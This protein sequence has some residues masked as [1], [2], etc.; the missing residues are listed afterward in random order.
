MPDFFLSTI[1]ANIEEN[2]NVAPPLVTVTASDADSIAT[3]FGS[4][5]FS[6]EAGEG[7][8]S[9]SINQTGVL[10][11]IAPLDREEM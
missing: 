10:T 8:D 9:F 6:I 2:R 7:S 1:A 11:A 3:G 4:L 5:S